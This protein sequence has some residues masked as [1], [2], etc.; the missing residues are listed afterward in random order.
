MTP[1]E[2]DDLRCLLRQHSGLD[3]SRDK[4]ALV[5][6]R[7]TPF[8]RRGGFGDLAG[9]LRQVRAGE[10][11][12]IA[13]VA[14]AMTTN[15][16]SF[17]R[18]RAA[19][20]HLR[21]VILPALSRSRASRRRL[22]IWSA[23][24]STGQEPY[25]IAM[26]VKDFGAPFDGWQIEIVATD[27]SR[28]VLQRSED[29]L[30]SQFDVQ[31]GLPIHMLLDHFM[32]VGE[33]PVGQVWRIN[34][35]LRAMV[36]HR[37]FNLLHDCAPLGMF[38]VIFCRNVLIAFDDATRTR[39]L[40]GLSQ[41]L[42]TDGYLMLGGAETVRRLTDPFK[43]HPDRRGLYRRDLRAPLAPGVMPFKVVA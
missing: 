22:R 29:G 25:S 30:F 15:E 26:C 2:F 14:E 31:R 35:E 6:S 5:E 28:A 1:S 42:H 9:L 13:D 11:G 33:T 34:P 40:A 17:F 38:D 27:L 36:T 19:F 20:A 18:D 23:G 10:P 43:P 21:E 39:V 12:A 37:P 4:Q 8:A 24:C 7:L 3:L 32:P 16:T 41:A